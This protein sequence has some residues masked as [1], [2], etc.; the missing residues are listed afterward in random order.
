METT[1]VGLR[2]LI[3]IPTSI[4]FEEI[5]DIEDIKNRALSGKKP[6]D[7]FGV[8]LGINPSVKEIN[9]FVYTYCF[10]RGM[11]NQKK[12]EDL[13]A[14]VAAAV[15]VKESKELELHQYYLDLIQS[16]YNY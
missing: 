16:S 10:K 11:Y 7:Y 13:I 12:I 1:E 3:R 9:S 15:A 5:I 8:S 4:K 14:R 2:K 6:Y